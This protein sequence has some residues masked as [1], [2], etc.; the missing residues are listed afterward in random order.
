MPEQQVVKP[1]FKCDACG[2]RYTWKPQIA[3]R[4]AKCKCGA[5]LL[6][7]KTNP[8]E[9]KRASAPPA[10]RAAVVVEDDVPNFD[11]YDVSAPEEE[12]AAA[13]PP[14]PPAMAARG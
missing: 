6:V 5:V 3:G 13:A 14:P 11:E 12:D 10:P 4:Q 9:S 7:P 1:K 8:M 2:E